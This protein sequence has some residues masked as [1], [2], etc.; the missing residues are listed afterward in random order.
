MFAFFFLLLT[1][2]IIVKPQCVYE[3]EFFI[4]S[5]KGKKSTFALYCVSFENIFYICGKV[6]E[7]N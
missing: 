1:V 2:S 6:I 5:G 7:K 3:C 4:V